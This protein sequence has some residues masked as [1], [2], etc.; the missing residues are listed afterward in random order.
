MASL[1]RCSGAFFL[2]LL[3]VQ[4]IAVSGLQVQPFGEFRGQNGCPVL[5]Y[6]I[7]LR[8]LIKRFFQDN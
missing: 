7:V 6:E 2:L 4:L 3:L 8:G 5:A 1:S